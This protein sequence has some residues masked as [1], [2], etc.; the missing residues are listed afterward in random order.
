MRRIAVTL[1]LLTS[2]SLFAQGFDSGG[3]NAKAGAMGGAFVAQAD[4]ASAIF[5]N[6]GG[7]ALLKKKK[8]VAIT[9][10]TTAFQ[11]YSYQGLPPGIGTATTGEQTTSP[12]VVPH[13]FLTL[14]FKGGAVM[15][16][17]VYSPTR[18]RSSWEN[19]ATYAGRRSAFS[20]KLDVLDLAPALG[21]RF[22]SLGLGGA[23]IQRRA[24]FQA[25]RR[26]AAQFAGTPTDVA[27]L[28]MKSDTTSSLGWRVG[29]LH[30][31]SDRF[32]W[33]VTYTTKFDDDVDGVG[34]LTQIATGDAQFDQLVKAS[35]PFGQDLP[36][37]TRLEFPAQLR[38][39]VAFGGTFLVEIDAV[40]SSW[41]K[42]QPALALLFPANG[43]FDTIYPLGFKDTTDIHAGLR[44]QF[45]TG[46]QLRFGFAT[47]KSPLPDEAVGALIPDAD[48]NTISAGFGL[49]WLHLGVAWTTFS[50]RGV[51]TSSGGL[52]GNYKGNRWSALLTIVK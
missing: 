23:V 34:A 32:S 30:K 13:A 38:A 15:G 14:P 29:L 24:S 21:V 40:K 19:E 20:S 27:T 6:P 26:V 9:A 22:G 48:G 36:L 1:A 33:G 45:P 11:Q 8:G 46:P 2:V 42:T 28:A 3:Q 4:D 50:T 49:D 51:S 47:A 35:F 17:G 52:N 7:L 18:M 16:L 12:Q 44:W 10:A 39:G 43:T 31:P 5:Y 41:S 25:S 37:A